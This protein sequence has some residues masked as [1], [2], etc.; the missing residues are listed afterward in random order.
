MGGHM[1]TPELIKEDLVHVGGCIYRLTRY[2]RGQWSKLGKIHWG[3]SGLETIEER[4][5]IRVPHTFM[6]FEQTPP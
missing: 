6:V 5:I 3:L 1:E 2:F 4:E